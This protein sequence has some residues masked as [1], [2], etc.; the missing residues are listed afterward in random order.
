MMKKLEPTYFSQSAA[1]PATLLTAAE[2][3]RELEHAN[4]ARQLALLANEHNS[5]HAK[6]LDRLCSAAFVAEDVE[7]LLQN[8]IELFVQIASVEAGVLRLREGDRIRSRA[9]VGLEEEVAGGFTAP[10]PNPSSSSEVVKSD[11]LRAKGFRTQSSFVLVDRGEVLGEVVLGALDDREFSS[12]ERETLDLLAHHA[13]AAIRRGLAEEMLRASLSARDQVL[14]VVA[15]DLK[16]PINVIAITATGILG[17]AEDPTARRPMERI[18]RG[19][20]RAERLLRD[21]L[22]IS[23]IES[24]RL[25]ID[26][27]RIEP[28]DLVLAALESQHSIAEGASVIVSSDVAPELPPIDADEERLMEVF[29]NLIG[30]AVKFTGANGSVTVGAGRREDNLLFWV[31][32]TGPGVTPEELPRVF[33]RFWHAKKANRRGTG[34]GLSI[35]KG[36]VEAH[37]G[38]IW[39]ETTLGRGTTVFFTIP[40]PAASKAPSDETDVANILLV[41][42]RPENLLSLK[43]ILERPDYRLVF[44]SSGEEALALA[45]RER[46]ALALIDVAMPGMNG[47][48]VAIHMKELERSRGIPIIFITAFGDDPQEI[49]RAYSAGGADYLVKPLDPEIVRKKVAVFVD[50]NRRRLEKH[51]NT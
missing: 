28:A 6:A 39:L 42:D 7:T 25:A 8:L 16:N 41:D 38:R 24:G 50:L 9:S 26:R 5:R 31:K 33:D 46:F 44:A 13:A 49:H 23:A 51:S 27:R 37:G 30:N 15:H 36:I 20:R 1:E 48:E 45:L 29:E 43:A 10:L 32:D 35:C 4:E 2:L 12:E 21:L 3:M 17:R 47:L 19:V 18:L 14:S 11:A 34:L 40:I 22:E